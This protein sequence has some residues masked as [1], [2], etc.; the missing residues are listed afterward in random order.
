MSGYKCPLCRHLFTNGPVL[1]ETRGIRLSHLTT[2]HLGFGIVN[3]KSVHC[4]IMGCHFIC[5]SFEAFELHCE[6]RHY[7]G[8][9]SY[10]CKDCPAKAIPFL[11]QISLVRH[12]YYGHGKNRYKENETLM[13]KKKM[14]KRIRSGSVDM[15]WI[16]GESNV[17]SIENGKGSIKKMKYK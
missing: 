11:S 9:G 7:D 17:Y 8:G 3:G 1:K 4:P 5:P 2:N 10:R 14:C 13:K 12:E 6:K 16:I 15:R